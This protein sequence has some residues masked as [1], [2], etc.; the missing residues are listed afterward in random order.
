MQPQVVAPR[1]NGHGEGNRTGVGPPE[2]IF[3]HGILPWGFPFCRV[4]RAMGDK[5]YTAASHAS[6]LGSQAYQSDSACIGRGV[7][8]KFPFP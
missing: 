7:R 6:R 4:I 8:G 1:E 2:V 5:P 3:A